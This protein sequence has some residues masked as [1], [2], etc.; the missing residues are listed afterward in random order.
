[1]TFAQNQSANKYPSTPHNWMEID[2]PARRDPCHLCPDC[3]EDNAAL[4]LDIFDLIG[5]K[6]EQMES[7]G[8]N[9]IR[10]LTALP[11]V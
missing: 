6:Y 1:M 7:Q 3:N 2:T 9:K 8:V 10:I 11:R 4:V 5:I